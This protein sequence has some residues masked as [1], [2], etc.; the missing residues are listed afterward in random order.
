[1]SRRLQQRTDWI[2]EACDDA[3]DIFDSVQCASQAE[4]LSRAADL[5][6]QHPQCLYVDTGRC[7]TWGDDR[8]GMVKDEY[9]Y[10]LR[11]HRDGRTEPA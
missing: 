3:G 1:M 7:R 10:T 8:D 2:A 5:F 11:V 6:A 4:A 9:S